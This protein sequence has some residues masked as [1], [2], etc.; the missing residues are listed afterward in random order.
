MRL[1][2]GAKPDGGKADGAK[3]AVPPKKPGA[4][5]PIRVVV[6]VRTP[7]KPGDAIS[8]V[9]EPRIGNY[10]SMAKPTPLRRQDDQGKER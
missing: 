10:V 1:E 5:N 8:T 9:S 2:E 3:K 6:R 7:L 4:A